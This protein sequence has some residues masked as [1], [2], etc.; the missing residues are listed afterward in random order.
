MPILARFTNFLDFYDFGKAVALNFEIHSIS[1]F[2]LKKFCFLVTQGPVK[3][4]IQRVKTARSFLQSVK[5]FHFII[6]S[7][8][9]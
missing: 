4:Y 6:L 7:F 1:C 9:M 5:S 8:P 2:L 3:L